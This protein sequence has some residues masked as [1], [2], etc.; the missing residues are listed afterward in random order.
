MVMMSE[1]KVDRYLRYATDD[2]YKNEEK[3]I[4]CVHR[5]CKLM[6]L[7]H[8]YSSVVRDHLLMRGFMDGA[9]SMNDD[10]VEV[11]AAPMVVHD[12]EGHHDMM[13]VEN[14]NEGEEEEPSAHDNREVDIFYAET[15]TPLTTSFARTAC[16]ADE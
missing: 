12:D 16:K 13:I 6:T 3:E 11:H 14:N 10:D 2:M 5:K 1:G 9:P 4:R 7:H 8:P 15:Q